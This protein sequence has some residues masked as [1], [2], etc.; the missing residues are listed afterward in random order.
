MKMYCAL[1]ITETINSV[2]MTAGIFQNSWVDR[3]RKRGSEGGG[4]FSGSEGVGVGRGDCYGIGRIGGKFS[5][6]FC[7]RIKTQDVGT[8]KKG[9]GG[10][11]RSGLMAM[12]SGN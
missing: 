8:T 6:I 12:G 7:N 9:V 4:Y 1:N 3:G 2:I 10:G 11:K 5:A